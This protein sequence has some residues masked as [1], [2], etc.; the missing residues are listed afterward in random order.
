MTQH[1]EAQVQV[2]AQ[3]AGAHPQMMTQHVEFLEA[4]TD[5]IV[6]TQDRFEAN[7]LPAVQAITD[8]RKTQPVAEPGLT[9]L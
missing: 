7:V 5:Q 1:A 3:K 6:E 8:A 9:S 4:M 2:M